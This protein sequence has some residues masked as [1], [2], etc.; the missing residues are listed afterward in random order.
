MNKRNSLLQHIKLTRRDSEFAKDIVFSEID[1]AKESIHT[2]VH[3][4]S[5]GM[6]L[7]SADTKKPTKY[8]RMFELL[9]V[10]ENNLTYPEIAREVGGANVEKFVH[11]C[12]L[13]AIGKAVKLSR[14]NKVY[15]RILDDYFK[16]L[17][18]FM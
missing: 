10:D 12:N 13:I 3:N 6:D 7:A 17:K 15:T 14:E 2:L 18:S 1:T 9:F 11:K 4:W 16:W 5:E 8:Q